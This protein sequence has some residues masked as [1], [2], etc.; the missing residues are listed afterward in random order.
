MPWWWP[1]GGLFEQKLVLQSIPAAQVKS[2]REHHGPW[3]VSGE[4]VDPLLSHLY[5]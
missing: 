3:R 4:A 5:A 1:W 2:P